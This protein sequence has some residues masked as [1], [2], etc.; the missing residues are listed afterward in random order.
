[1]LGKGRFLADLEDEQ[2]PPRL[3]GYES[4]LYQMPSIIGTG[5]VFVS[6]R[7]MAHAG[8]ASEPPTRWLI[9]VGDVNGL[10]DAASRLKKLIEVAIARLASTTSDPASILEALNADPLD[11]DSFPI[12]L[13]ALIDSERH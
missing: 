10:G 7:L 13:V 8:L 6:L 9:A 2:K 3:A 5:D 11:P 4:W 12:L 1:M